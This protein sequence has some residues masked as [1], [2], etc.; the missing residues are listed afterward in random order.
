M[1]NAVGDPQLRVTSEL[2][3]DTRIVAMECWALEAESLDGTEVFF[4]SA[5]RNGMGV[6]YVTFEGYNSP[7]AKLEWLTFLKS[8]GKA[9]LSDPTEEAR[10]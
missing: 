4:Q 5:F 2:K 9:E 7:T 3:M 8:V 10:R 6:L 1:S